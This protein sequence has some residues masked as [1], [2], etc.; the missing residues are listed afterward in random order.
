MFRIGKQNC[1]HDIHKRI[2]IMRPKHEDI[3]QEY[4][5]KAKSQCEHWKA[6]FTE[7]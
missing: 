4:I 6:N 5:D 3:K 7:V 1:P 2:E